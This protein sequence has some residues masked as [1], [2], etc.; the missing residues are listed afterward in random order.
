MTSHPLA[1]GRPETGMLAWA[2]FFQVTGDSHRGI[3]LSEVSRSAI[4]SRLRVPAA[5]GR[6]ELPTANR[7]PLTGTT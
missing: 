4:G 2:I 5:N 3:G 6:D 7:L 1:Q